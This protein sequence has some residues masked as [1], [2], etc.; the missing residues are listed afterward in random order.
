MKKRLCV[1]GVIISVLVAMGC[2]GPADVKKPVDNSIVL[3]DVHFSYHKENGSHG[4]ETSND[5]SDK[6]NKKDFALAKSNPCDY[7]L[8]DFTI[9]AASFVRFSISAKFPALIKS[10][11]TIQ[12]P[13]Q[14]KILSHAR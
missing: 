6:K 13:P 10:P 12:L 3:K 14:A 4:F 8:T 9:A 1:L 11:F 7:P 5:V 2:A